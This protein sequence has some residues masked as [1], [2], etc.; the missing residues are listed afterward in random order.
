MKEFVARLVAWGPQ[1]LFLLALLDGIG[2]PLPGGVDFL[3]VVLAASDPAKAYQFAAITTVASIGGGVIL[4]YLA[5]KG[6]EALLRKHTSTGNGRKFKRWFQ[7]YGLVTLFIP[8]F[9][10]VPLPLKVFVICA[11]ALGI[12]FRAYLLTLLVARIPRFFALAWLGATY[13]KDAWP[14]I[15]SHGWHMAGI[16]LLLFVLITVG[17]RYTSVE[18]DSLEEASS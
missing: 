6:G 14:W 18:D 5:Q 13:G 12:R 10:I 8:A 17:I 9:V 4:Y 2:V 1:G 15:K 11:G 16:A 7:R 3:L